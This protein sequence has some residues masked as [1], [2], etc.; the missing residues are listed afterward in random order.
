MPTAEDQKT[1]E[2]KP[3]EQKPAAQASEQKP[4]DQKPAE[5]QPADTTPAAQKPAEQKP[6]STAKPDAPE[7]QKPQAPA[8]YSLVVPDH[9]PYTVADLA[10]MADTAKALGLTNEAAQAMVNQRAQ[11][12][13]TLNDRYLADLQADPELGGAHFDTTVQHAQ[14]GLE[15]LF[16]K[17]SADGALVRAWFNKT[18]LGNHTAF[19]RAMARIGKARAGDTHVTGEGTSGTVEKTAAEKLYPN[20]AP[21]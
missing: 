21:A 11:E 3:V 2:Q 9:S 16:P 20:M 17:D 13:A 6:D 18:G 7:G 19:V 4:T 12:L 15:W 5:Q 10:V 8:A 14:T 1:D